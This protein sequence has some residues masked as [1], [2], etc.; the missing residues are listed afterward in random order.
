MNDFYEAGDVYLGIFTVHSGVEAGPLTLKAAGSLEQEETQHM[1]IIAVASLII[2]CNSGIHLSFNSYL[3]HHT[4]VPLCKV[5]P[6]LL[7]LK[8]R[9]TELMTRGRAI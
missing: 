7:N 2:R 8:G 5:K 1:I 9:T 4:V 3:L 6:L